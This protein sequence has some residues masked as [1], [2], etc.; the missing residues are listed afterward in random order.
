MA[1]LRELLKEEQ[2]PFLLKN[3]ISEKRSQMK[4][5]LQLLNTKKHQ[6]SINLCRNA[7]FQSFPS[8]ITKSPLLEFTSPL[9]NTPNAKV[10]SKTATLLLQAALTIQRNKKHLASF[11]KR[12]S[13]RKKGI[14]AA[15]VSLSEMEETS[16]SGHS[17]DEDI[18]FQEKQKHTADDQ[19]YASPFRFVLQRNPS[20]SSGRRTPEFSSPPTSS[21]RHTTQDKESNGVDGVNKFQSEEEEED[22]EQCSP[23][24]VLDPPFDDD[25]DDGHENDHDQEDGFDL[26]C[27]YANVQRTKQQLLN[28][29]RRF[30]ELAELDAVELEKRMLDEEE[31]E[32]EK[33]MEEDDYDDGDSD[34]TCEEKGLRDTVFNILCHSRVHDIWHAP[35]DLKRLV[36]DL[37]MEEE[38]ELNS[39]EDRELVIRRVC[40]R[41]ELWKQVESNT[42]DMMIEEDFSIEEGRWKKNGEQTREL[43]EE[44]ELPIFCFLLEELFEEL[45]R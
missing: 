30:E 44:L 38:K 35:E 34:T 19:R 32:Y 26:E 42:I 18:P 10:P 22:K 36:H 2:E 23:V 3:Y 9:N 11:F 45:V 43:A 33:V 8:Q 16:C 24:S 15:H 37:I 4:R 12:L 31:N 1:H 7:C 25:D 21:S 14:Q 39:L 28:R 20:S 5:P 6:N 13:I 41:L 27:S 40:R 17:F 29:L